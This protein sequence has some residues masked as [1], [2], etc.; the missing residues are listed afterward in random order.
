MPWL[1]SGDLA[2][3]GVLTETQYGVTRDVNF[4]RDTKGFTA[5]LGAEVK[6]I[7]RESKTVTVRMASGETVEHGYG[8]L[9]LATG[10]TPKEAPF[11]VPESPL[12]QTFHTLDDAAHFRKLAEQGK[13]GRAVVI[14]AGF[15]GV[16]LIGALGDLWGIETT[17]VEAEDRLLPYVLDTDMSAILHRHLQ[18]QDVVFHRRAKVKGIDLAPDGSPVVSIDGVGKVE[19]DYVF[20]CL[21]VRPNVAL[22]RDCGLEIG[23]TGAISVNEYMQTSDPNIY[24]GGDCVETMN[25]IT[26]E[27]F[28]I[29]MGSLANR[30]GWVIADHI[31]GGSI[32]YN[33]AVGAFIVK[34]GELNVATVGLTQAAAEKAG[35]APD[36][37]WGTYSDRPTYF[38]E[39]DDIVCKLVYR[40]DN[41]CLL[42]LQVVGR[43]DVCRRADVFSAF[44]YHASTIKDLFD[45]EHAYAPPF[46]E[47]LDPLY[48]L[49][50]QAMA[51]QR[52]VVFESPDFDSGDAGTQWLD[53]R[54]EDE[55]KAEPLPESAAP[56]E[57][58]WLVIP[59]GELRGRLGELDPEKPVRIICARGPRSYQAAVVLRQ[60]GFKNVTIIGGGL[61]ALKE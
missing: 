38:M 42:G 55:I 25:R 28:Y 34:V 21:G 46:S 5:H 6:A 44:L 2:G 53:V 27:K 17:I 45:H 9:V 19:T 20:I 57:R 15:I 30:H 59:I 18:A 29:P 8:K 56:E 36:A 52:G 47:A 23:A 14:G 24:A 50:C 1:A 35:Y 10:A 4:F 48:H 43:G 58:Q 7:N 37:V 13:V 16:E 3:P 39:H 33:G 12:V 54:E 26:G 22:A 41:L 31:D 60:N 49:A 61:H 40:P 51:Q 11:P 32:P